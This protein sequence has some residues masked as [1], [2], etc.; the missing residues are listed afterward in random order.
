MHVQKLPSCVLRFRRNPALS[1]GLNDIPSFHSLL[2]LHAQVAVA[3]DIARTATRQAIGFNGRMERTIFYGIKSVVKRASRLVR[4]WT[5]RR[6]ESQANIAGRPG[7]DAWVAEAYFYFFLFFFFRRSSRECPYFRPGNS[8]RADKSG[9]TESLH[10]RNN[11]Y[12]G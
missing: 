12:T 11:E 1:Q 2:Q 5:P 9:E 8:I 10:V 6:S 4:A 7:I 3:F